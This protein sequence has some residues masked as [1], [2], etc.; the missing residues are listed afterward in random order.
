MS[1]ERTSAKGP[2]LVSMPGTG[3]DPELVAE[4]RRCISAQQIQEQSGRGARR[5]FSAGLRD[6]QGI[7]SW[8]Q[9]N[10]RLPQAASRNP[11]PR[12]RIF[13]NHEIRKIR[14]SVRGKGLEVSRI[15]RISWWTPF[16]ILAWILRFLIPCGFHSGFG[17]LG[18]DWGETRLGWTCGRKPGLEKAI[19][20]GVGTARRAARGRLG[21]ATLQN[22]ICA[23]DEFSLSPAS[24][25]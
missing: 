18:E 25:S 4:G 5:R 17:S 6:C 20:I 10:R 23:L 21:E 9:H 19:S 1:K 24:N 2:S 11:N 3:D 22:L 12:L 16:S 13:F 8:R 14:E 7:H 15:S